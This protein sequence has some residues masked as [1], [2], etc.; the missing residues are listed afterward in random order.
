[1]LIKS[2]QNEVTETI[3]H[4]VARCFQ[5]TQQCVTVPKGICYVPA[6][7]YLLGNQ[8]WIENTV[9]EIVSHI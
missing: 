8:V 1:M 6:T 4:I 7:V 9:T 5:S 3:G 2:N